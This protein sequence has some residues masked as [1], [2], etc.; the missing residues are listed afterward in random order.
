MKQ[1]IMMMTS[2]IEV[3]ENYDDM[4]HGISTTKERWTEELLCSKQCCL[5]HMREKN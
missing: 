1:Q 3:G 5:D 4:F 2:L